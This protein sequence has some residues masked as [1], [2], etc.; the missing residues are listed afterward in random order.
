MKTG[1][2]FVLT[3]A[4]LTGCSTRPRDFKPGLAAV[5]VDQQVYVRDFAVCKMMVDRGIRGNFPKQA[6]ALAPGVAA[7]TAGVTIAYTA[8]FANIGSSIGAGLVNAIAST[9]GQ[10]TP[11]ATA[12]T[13][14]A[15]AAATAIPVAG[16][17]VSVAISAG[18]KRK[19][20]KKVKSALGSCMKEYGHEIAE[21]QRDR[22]TN[23]NL[24][25]ELPQDPTT[26]EK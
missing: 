7:G 21:W 24:P 23:P 6:V 17:L 11:I 26:P 18:V 19:N 13:T 15:G 10:T 22:S 8:A 16:V 9:V 1:I 14:G 25:S 12:T 3:L 5:P 20:E 2:G 4:L